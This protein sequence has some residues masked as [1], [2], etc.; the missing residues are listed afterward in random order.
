MTQEVTSIAA[1]VR[2]HMKA[3]QYAT[4]T[5]IIDA[6]P[7]YEP[8]KLGG[9]LERLAVMGDVR[10]V[11]LIEGKRRDGKR[12]MMTQYKYVKD[13][14]R[15]PGPLKHA[16]NKTLLDVQPRGARAARTKYLVKVAPSGVEPGY[17]T[18]PFRAASEALP[19]GFP[20]KFDWDGVRKAQEPMPIAMLQTILRRE[21]DSRTG[22]GWG[23]GTSVM[24][25]T[26]MQA[27]PAFMGHLPGLAA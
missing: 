4:L 14:S 20:P 2:A 18:A 5:E 27:R 15:A 1:K 12:K 10:K 13:S 26:P 21:L 17:F 24:P 23:G 19:D 3:H 22:K 8:S 9:A 7:G 6:I 16:R 25:N 11:G